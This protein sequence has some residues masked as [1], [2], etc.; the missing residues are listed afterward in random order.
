MIVI[1][2][3]SK[4]EVDIIIFDDEIYD[5]IADDTCPTKDDF[6][7]PYKDIE[8]IGCYLDNKIIGLA[9]ADKDGKFHFQVL[10]QY[11]K[12]AREVLKQIL[13]KLDR[14]LY[15]EIP[16]CYKSVINFAKNN[17]FREVGTIDNRKYIKSNIDYYRTRLIFNKNSLE[18]RI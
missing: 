5:R 17:G 12:Y 13:D 2:E 3:P 15:C 1:K 16:T 4:E 18:K 8:F 14:S 7:I 10:K 11:R 6:I 9:N